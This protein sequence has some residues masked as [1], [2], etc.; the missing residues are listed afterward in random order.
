VKLRFRAQLSTG[1]VG[2]LLLRTQA[3]NT[4]VCMLCTQEVGVRL[5]AVPDFPVPLI[6][7]P[8]PHSLLRTPSC[9]CTQYIWTMTPLMLFHLLVASDHRTYTHT[10][11]CCLDT[12]GVGGGTCKQLTE[13][14]SCIHYNL[15][16]HFT[17]Q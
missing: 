4:M 13:I 16:H 15:Q 9:S 10:H 8:I 2:M 5:V 6:P 11:T 17:L 14:H 7:I 12:S 3:R 1:K